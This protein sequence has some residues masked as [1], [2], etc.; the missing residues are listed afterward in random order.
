MSERKPLTPESLFEL[1][2]ASDVQ[3]AP[4]GQRVAY[5]EHW[6]EEIEK[7]GKE[8]KVY[9]TAIYLSE[10]EHARPRRVTFTAK[11]SDSSPRW[12]PDGTRLAFLST[13]DD[14]KQQLFL[15]NL[16]GGEAEQIT[17]TEDLSEGVQEFDW[18]PS[19][20]LLCFTSRGHKDDEAKKREEINDEKVYENHLPFKFNGQGL[21][22]ERRAQLYRLHLDDGTCVQLTQHS[23]TIGAP[24]WSPDGQHIAFISKSEE[25]PEHTWIS[26]LFVIN[27]G[28]GDLQQITPSQ[29][30]VYNFSWSPDGTRLAFVGHDRRQGFASTARLWLVDAQAGSTPQ[31][32]TDGFEGS[33]DD[34]PSSDTHLGANPLDPYWEDDQHIVVE[35]L[36]QGRAGLYRVTLPNGEIEQI[37]TSGLSVVGFSQRGSMIAFTGETNARTAEVYVMSAGTRPQRRSHVAD[38]FFSTYRIQPPEHVRFPSVEDFEIEGWFIRPLDFEE[39]QKYPLLLYVHGGPHLAFGNALFHE[40]Q[41][42]AA[43]GYGVLYVNPRGSSSYG[44]EF[45]AAVRRHFGENDFQDIMHAAD[46]A[47]SWE[48]VDETRMGILGGSYGGFMTNWVITHTDRF[49]A[50]CT[51]RCISNVYSFAGSSD[52]GPEFSQ[53]EFG[54]LPWLDEELLMSKSPIR[55]VQNIKTPTLI[56]HPEADHRCPIEQSEQLYTALVML[57][58][59]T[60]LVRFPDENHELSR[61]GQPQRRVNRMHHIVDWFDRYLKA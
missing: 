48:W 5:V 34:V 35:A 58:V 56:L 50:A 39:G 51:Q 10:S 57:G 9:R 8:R 42:H 7:D 16:Q 6:V 54:T 18:H 45:T 49:A 44:E 11:A 29:G 55:Y 21:L 19:G 41:V 4:D 30:P 22:D 14:D 1:R 43:A 23:R 52:I 25:T 17:F 40:F 28:G 15:L 2:W 13:R 60:K 20:R 36:E 59:P 24:K 46:L 12:S 61:S 31:C 33:L 3:L 27:T 53:D 32:V 38:A 26:D 37:S 47:A